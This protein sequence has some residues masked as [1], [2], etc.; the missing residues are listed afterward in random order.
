MSHRQT[1]T[2]T[3][4]HSETN[5]ICLLALSQQGNNCYKNHLSPDVF[6]SF[7]ILPQVKN[8]WQELAF[9]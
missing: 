1:C 7:I 2:T 9:L 3:Y 5:K 8:N 4:T 6:F